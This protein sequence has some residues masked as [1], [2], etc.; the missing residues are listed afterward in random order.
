MKWPGCNGDPPDRLKVITHSLP[1]VAPAV[2][3]I[4]PSFGWRRSSSDVSSTMNTGTLDVD[5]PVSAT[6][7]QNLL[8]GSNPRGKAML[9]SPSSGTS[10]T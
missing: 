2:A 5:D 10:V 7:F 3:S 4:V 1:P 6:T 9:T 8:S